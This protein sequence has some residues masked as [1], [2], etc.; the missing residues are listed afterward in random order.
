MVLE[1]TVDMSLDLELRSKEYNLVIY[2]D[3]ECCRTEKNTINLST[4]I[5]PAVK[6]EIEFARNSRE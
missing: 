5:D 6:G 2:R 4:S 3:V 1:S